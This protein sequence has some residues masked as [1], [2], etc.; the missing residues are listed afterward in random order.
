MIERKHIFTSSISAAAAVLA[1][2]S[3]ARSGSEEWDS[4]LGRRHRAHLTSIHDIRVLLRHDS[5]Y[6]RQL[7]AAPCILLLSHLETSAPS[8]CI[9]TVMGELPAMT[10]GKFDAH[11]RKFR[12]HE[13]QQ[14][15]GRDVTGLFIKRREKSRQD[16]RVA[17]HGPRTRPDVAIPEQGSSASWRPS[18]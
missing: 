17:Q 10:K 8:S 13:T 7:P 12:C 5:L 18:S 14:Y 1:C 3:S 4:A 15:A 9:M 2:H 6:S 16:S 11:N